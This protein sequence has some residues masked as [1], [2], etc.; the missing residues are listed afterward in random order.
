M[1]SGGPIFPAHLGCVGIY[2]NKG[3]LR[4]ARVGNHIARAAG[5]P[6][7]SPVMKNSDNNVGLVHA[8]KSGFRKRTSSPGRIVQFIWTAWY[9]DYFAV[10][11]LSHFLSR[12]LSLIRIWEI[13]LVE[14][15]FFGERENAYPRHPRLR[16]FCREQ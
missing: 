5:F 4:R 10:R 8:S 13:M 15:C 3:T 16:R 12:G 14:E 7:G 2:N 9:S 6:W 1:Q 11:R